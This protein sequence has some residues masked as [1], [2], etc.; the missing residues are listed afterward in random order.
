MKK[1]GV[2]DLDS[3]LR[4]PSGHGEINEIDLCT[5]LLSRMLCPIHLT[6]LVLRKVT[7][8]GDEYT[9]VQYGCMTCRCR[10]DFVGDELKSDSVGRTLDFVNSMIKEVREMEAA[11]TKSNSKVGVTV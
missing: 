3:V 10:A 2:W 6:P 9:R 8:L 11:K 5:D 7:R 1:I 4:H